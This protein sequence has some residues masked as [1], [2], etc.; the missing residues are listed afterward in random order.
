MRAFSLVRG[1]RSYC[2]WGEQTSHYGNIFCCTTW[3]LGTRP[4]VVA[5]R[6]FTSCGYWSRAQAQNLWLHGV[7]DLPRPEF[8]SMSP[9]FNSLP[10]SRQR[11]P[12]L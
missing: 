12:D 4:S 7:W 5:V 3:A 6:G 8:E 2:V 9:A 10:L 1:S 11:S